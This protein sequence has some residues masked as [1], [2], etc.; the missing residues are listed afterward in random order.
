[1]KK[2]F[3]FL[4]ITI[5]F[6]GCSIKRDN[7]EDINICTTIYP[8]EYITNRLYGKHSNIYSIYPDGTNARDYTLTNKQI[9]DYSDAS[10]FIFNGLSKEKDYVIPL[11]KN[12]KN[13]K[14]IDTTLSMEYNNEIEELWMDPSNF[15]MLS[16]NIRTGLKEYINNHYLQNEIDENYENL[17]IDISNIEANLR[18]VAQ[19]SN[20][21][22][23]IVS[24]DLYKF[25][26]KYGFNVISLE[27]N[28]NLTDKIINTAEVLLSN[29]SNSYIFTLQN[30]EESKTIKDIVA[31]TDA[32]VIPLHSLS[33]I[34]ENERNSKKDYITLMNENIEL[35]KNEL[36]D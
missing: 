4:I 8:T 28:D 14:I 24:S 32:T 2:I 9:K 15:L 23:I 13:I 29:N 17:K 7:L 20:N 27:E 26:E 3:T 30:E 33:N 11:F 21:P 31:S 25:L 6:T 12:N 19:S 35:L 34:T 5:F 18:I 36:Y 22:T 10:I 1:M 16:Q